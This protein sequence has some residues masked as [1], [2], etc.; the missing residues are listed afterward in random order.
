MYI[1]RDDNEKDNCSEANDEKDHVDEEEKDNG[2][3][4]GGEP[5]PH[6]G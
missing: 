1:Q 2:E 5:G 3:G 4:E 6:D